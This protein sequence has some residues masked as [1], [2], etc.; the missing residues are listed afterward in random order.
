LAVTAIEVLQ[1]YKDENLPAFLGIA[2]TDVNQV[3]LFGERPLDV[4]AVR[5]D[6]EE[7][8]ALLEGGA[9]VNASAE[10]GNTALHEAVS[11]GHAEAVKLLLE[12][13]ASGE[14]RNEFGETPLDIARSRNR[15]DILAI[16]KAVK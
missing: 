15:Y 7:I 2:L 14:V 16:F 12:S 10:H 8:L 4:A 1:R 11:Q 6:L 9:E 13:G 5:G 3:G